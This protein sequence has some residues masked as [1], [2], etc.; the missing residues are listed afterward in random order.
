MS[1]TAAPVPLPPVS[2]VTVTSRKPVG[3]FVAT[4]RIAVSWV[5]LSTLTVPTDTPVPLTLT[6][7][8]LAKLFP[9]T[10]TDWFVAP[11]GSRVGLAAVTV[12]WDSMRTPHVYVRPSWTIASDDGVTEFTS[13]FC[14]AA[15]TRASPSTLSF[16]FLLTRAAT[17]RRTSW[18]FRMPG[19]GKAKA[20]P[21]QRYL[22]TAA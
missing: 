4:V 3:A 19:R 13:A 9:V 15:V 6:V 12:T 22:K 8:P 14:A 17:A 18:M 10:V 11:C 5:P 7:A 1:S 16:S 2:F 20:L 21:Q